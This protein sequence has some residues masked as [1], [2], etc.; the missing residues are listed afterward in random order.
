MNTIYATVSFPTNPS[1]SLHYSTI[2][3]H[4]SLDKADGEALILKPSSAACEYSTVKYSQSPT[5]ST[6]NQPSRPSEDPLYSTVNLPQQQWGKIRP[7]RD[8]WD[9]LTAWPR[10]QVIHF[11]SDC[12]HWNPAQT[13]A[14]T[15]SFSDNVNSD[16][17]QWSGDTQD[18]HNNPHSLSH[19]GFVTELWHWSVM[20]QWVLFQSFLFFL[21]YLLLSAPEAQ[22]VD[23]LNQ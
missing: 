9:V 4:N 6:V 10:F 13:S 20:I 2:N 15:Q 18:S 5:Y 23:C 16:K 22:L 11:W 1:D 17:S 21:F 8:L 7:L 12:L 19:K 14:L 3:F